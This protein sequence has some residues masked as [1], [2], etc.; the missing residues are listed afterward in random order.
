MVKGF[1]LDHREGEGNVLKTRRPARVIGRCP[2]HNIR[3][4]TR[5]DGENFSKRNNFAGEKSQ[6]SFRTTRNYYTV[7]LEKFLQGCQNLPFEGKTLVQENRL[8]TG[9]NPWAYYFCFKMVQF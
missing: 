2:P 7:I 1:G 3:N 9:T 4:L 8:Q 5:N 6:C